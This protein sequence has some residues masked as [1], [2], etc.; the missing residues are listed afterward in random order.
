MP[1]FAVF[2]EDKRYRYV[3]GRTQHGHTKTLWSETATSAPL[4]AIGLNPST[5]DARRND[6]STTRLV[7][8][9]KRWGYSGVIWVNLFGYQSTDPDGLLIPDDPVGPE[10]DRYILEQTQN[11]DVLC[12]WGTALVVEK[13]ANEIGV[14]ERCGQVIQMLSQKGKAN[15]LLTLGL[16]QHGEPKHPLYVK[17]AT[18]P[19][20]FKHCEHLEIGFHGEWVPTST[21]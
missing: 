11:R 21:P 9:G 18:D 12:C 16:T 20:D 14:Q 17:S 1:S 7:G 6:Q 4:V 19:Q 15:R 5:A 10:N 2:S 13:L 8:F 3:L